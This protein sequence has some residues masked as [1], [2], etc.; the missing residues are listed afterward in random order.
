MGRKKDVSAKEFDVLVGQ[1]E[2]EG[3]HGIPKPIS[4]QG[5]EVLAFDLEE[6]DKL[7]RARAWIK[8]QRTIKQTQKP[9]TATPKR[10]T[11]KK[12][13]SKKKQ[14]SGAKPDGQELTPEQLEMAERIRKRQIKVDASTTG[15]DNK[16]AKKKRRRRPKRK[17]K[18]SEDK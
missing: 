17:K 4:S 13:K 10:A 6:R 1:L 2:Q 12:P 15:S 18:Q 11:S 5:L 3:Y 16:P 8:S 14:E 9:E 7:A